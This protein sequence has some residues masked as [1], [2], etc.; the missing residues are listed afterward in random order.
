LE[1]KIF[2][3]ITRR[4]IACCSEDAVIS[5]VKVVARIRE[6]IFHAT[7]ITILEENFLEIYR[8]FYYLK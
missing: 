4:F 5:E 2:D 8:Q 3:L 6:E 1:Y 7:G